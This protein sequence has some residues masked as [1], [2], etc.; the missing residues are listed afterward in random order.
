MESDKKAK[1]TAL[2]SASAETAAIVRIEKVM[3]TLGID[4]QDRV[5]SLFVKRL[6]SAARALAIKAAATPEP[7]DEAPSN[8]VLIPTQ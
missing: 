8:G 2:S 6:Q 1:R 4:E 7:Q 5:L 3:A